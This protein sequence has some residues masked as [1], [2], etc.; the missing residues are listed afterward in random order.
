MDKSL[1][2]DLHVDNIC[3]RLSNSSPLKCIYRPLYRALVQP[4]MYYAYVVCVELP[5]I[6][7]CINRIIPLHS[8][9]YNSKAFFRATILQLQ[10]GKIVKQFAI[11]SY[12]KCRTL[13]RSI[14]KFAAYVIFSLEELS[15]FCY[16]CF[17]PI[18]FCVCTYFEQFSL[19]SP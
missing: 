10:S 11:R 16:N 15:Y 4:V 3:N 9:A 14:E 5:G 6:R 2:W 17:Y 13:K 12:R 8:K 7:S 18:M 1:S 19:S